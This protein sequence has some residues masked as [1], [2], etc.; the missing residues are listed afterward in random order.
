MKRLCLIVLAI[1]LVAGGISVAHP[2]QGAP[3]RFAHLDP[4]GQPRLA[5]QVPVNVVFVGYD[6]RDVNPREL[7][8]GLPRTYEPIVRSR[9]RVRRR[10]EAGHHLPLRLRLTFAGPRYEN[11]FFARARRGCPGRRR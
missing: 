7:R 3:P 11:R 6:R 1:A 5:E 10:G 9:A 4:G 2:A 8:G